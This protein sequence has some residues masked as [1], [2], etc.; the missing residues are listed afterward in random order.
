MSQL[1]FYVTLFVVFIV[2][3]AVIFKV[4]FP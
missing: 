2:L 3:S 1:L 4:F